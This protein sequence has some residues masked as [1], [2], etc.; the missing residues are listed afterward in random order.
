MFVFPHHQLNSITSLRWM[1]LLFL[2]LM[3]CPVQAQSDAS[4]VLALHEQKFRWMENRY[5][6]SLENVLHT[7]VIYVHSNGWRE[8]REEIIQNIRTGHLT[9]QKVTIL[10]AAIRLSGNTAVVNG[11]GRFEVALEGRPIEILLDYTEV[12]VFENDSWL[13]FSRHACK[14]TE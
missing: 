8:S 1:W 13:L 3:V 12:Y 14:L 10:E 7:E 5:I 6:D 2:L 11:K 9:Y 4:E